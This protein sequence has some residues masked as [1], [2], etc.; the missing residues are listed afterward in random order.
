MN[1]VH[2]GDVHVYPK[3]ELDPFP[4][5]LPEWLEHKY[6]LMMPIPESLTPCMKE[7]LFRAYASALVVPPE[8]MKFVRPPAVRGAIMEESLAPVRP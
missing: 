3:P 5:G 8:A 7:I 2:K 4:R 6:Y 1:W